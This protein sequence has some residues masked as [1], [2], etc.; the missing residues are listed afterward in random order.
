MKLCLGTAQFGMD[1][2]VQGDRKTN[3]DEVYEI[4]KCAIDNGIDLVDTAP[5]Y[6]EAEKVLGNFIAASSAA[7]IKVVSKLDAGCLKNI[8]RKNYKRVIAEKIY[9]SCDALHMDKLDGY[10][11][12]NPK[13]LYVPEV[14]TTLDELKNAGHIDHIGASVY[15]PKDALYAANSEL[16]D[17][18][19]VPYNALDH[20]LE[21]NGF[22]KQ[23]KENKKTIFARSVFL[24]GLLTMKPERIPPH[25]ASARDSVRTFQK[26]CDDAGYDPVEGSI[27]YIKNNTSIDYLV[28]GVNKCGQLEEI[29]EK[30]NAIDV[31]SES[32]VARIRETF[33]D[34]E[35]KLINPALWNR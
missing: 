30:Y 24:Q 17:Y 7:E 21:K 32:F 2:G 12:H 15:S 1:Y 13:H 6:G 34:M 33:G 20:G 8:A 25:L 14:L 9:N 35:E 27:A 11:L 16:V 3:A 19:Q 22:F 28:L 29:I 4:L 31:I 5:S 10:L 18:I 26:I 23:A